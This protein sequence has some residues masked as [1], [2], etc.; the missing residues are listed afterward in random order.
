MTEKTEKPLVVASNNQVT[1]TG[2]ENLVI[3][4]PDNFPM[5]LL[6]ALFPNKARQ[7]LL[8][9]AQTDVDIQKIR[10]EKA[11]FDARCNELIELDNSSGAGRAIELLN[12]HEDIIKKFNV[13]SAV[14]E[15]IIILQD[16]DISIEKDETFEEISPDW[17]ARWKAEVELTSNME[18]QKVWAMILAGEVKQPGR[19]NL[20]TLEVLKRF[21][22]R[23]AENFSKMLEMCPVPDFTVKKDKAWMEKEIGIGINTLLELEE[24][25]VLGSVASLGLSYSVSVNC[26]VNENECGIHLPHLNLVVLG[27]MPEATISLNGR[28]LTTAGLG[29]AQLAGYPETHIDIKNEIVQKMRKLPAA[30]GKEVKVFNTTGMDEKGMFNLA[31]EYTTD[32]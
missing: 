7:A 11:R 4:I 30:E 6:I 5:N 14:A 18:M 3:T 16:E 20:L 19:F 1:L 21:D 12:F 24:V 29:I 32:L 9:L 15:A 2:I 28:N 22:S 23:I 27:V 31:E 26:D 13:A 17:L 25:G 8:T 10:D